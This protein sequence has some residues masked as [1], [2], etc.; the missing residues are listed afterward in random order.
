LC[1][2]Q[3]I[4]EED[5]IAKKPSLAAVLA[6]SSL[7]LGLWLTTAASVPRLEDSTRLARLATL[8]EV[9]GDLFLF[10]PKGAT[11]DVDWGGL[12]ERA[13][14]AVERAATPTDLVDA[15]NRE[16]IAP[17]NDPLTFAFLDPSAHPGAQGRE[18][19]AVKMLDASTGLVT[20]PNASALDDTLVLQDLSRAVTGLG[21]VRRLVI[22]ARWT[23]VADEASAEWLRLWTDS[24][25]PMGR[26]VSRQHV[27]WREQQPDRANLMGLLTEQ[28]WVV[29]S[30]STLWPISER[31]TGPNAP[32]GGRALHL[33]PIHTPTLMLVNRVSLPALEHALDA[34]QRPGRFAIALERR[35]VPTAGGQAVAYAGALRLNLHGAVLVGHTG[36]LGPCTDFVADSI[37]PDQLPAVAKTALEGPRHPCA[38]RALFDYAVHSSMSSV[39]DTGA[40]TRERRLYGLFKIYAVM[41]H[42][43]RDPEV[44]VDWPRRLTSWISA[45]EAADSPR[46]YSAVLQEMAVSL[47][48]AHANVSGV[49]GY[50][51]QRDSAAGWMIPARI[52]RA[53]DG[54]AVVV[55]L[56]RV[57]DPN[58]PDGRSMASNPFKVGDEVLRIDGHPIDEIAAAAS[59]H[60]SATNGA[61]LERE[62]SENGWLGTLGPFKSQARVEV[63][64]ANGKTREITVQRNH[65]GWGQNSLF[66]AGV[67]RS[68]I[69]DGNVG[70]VSL[71]SLSGPQQ[72]DSIKVAMRNTDGLIIDNRSWRAGVVDYDLVRGWLWTTADSLP[73]NSNSSEIPVADFSR[74]TRNIGFVRQDWPPFA[75]ASF[76]ASGVYYTK[77]I[78]VLIGPLQSEAEVVPITVRNRHRGL[79]IGTETAGTTGNENAISLPGGGIFRFSTFRIRN[80]DG[81]LFDRVGVVP[82]VRV[83]PT[84][85]G[86]RAG[87]DEAVETG[88][89]ELKRL[90]GR[91]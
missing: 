81:S 53:R 54:R 59:Q 50:N 13:I 85:E 55:Q 47:H 15:L 71:G 63:R 60:I 62:L 9:W 11:S 38:T 41:T 68:R 77:P 65:K 4:L 1:D 30:G 91:Q 44:V 28:R 46:A 26:L 5:M 75:P 10:H 6:A 16:L 42:L 86:I 19:I 70:Y 89:A 22:D 73:N 88:I 2:K 8:A 58:A 76:N 87:R 74:T 80:P 51:A 43:Y 48:D 14:P 18:T 78:V 72:F 83:T 40:L 67:P 35:G 24:V 23:D 17:L 79:L 21:P 27:G 20:I 57:D 56:A 45:A 33:P 84:V 49:G 36:A 64:D 39:S 90:L 32:Y 61:H 29:E 66:L 25:I 31:L 37:A 69:L 52:V 82:D 12:L 7:L 3:E 34:L